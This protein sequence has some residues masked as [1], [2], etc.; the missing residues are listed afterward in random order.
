MSIDPT[1][2]SPAG[3]PITIKITGPNT[4]PTL[5]FEAASTDAPQDIYLALVFKATPTQSPLARQSLGVGGAISSLILVTITPTG[6]LPV[7]L[8]IKDFSPPTIHDSWLPLALTPS[9]SNNT[10]TMVRPEGLYEVISPVGKVVFTLPLYPHL[11]LGS[12][13]RLLKSSVSNL[14]SDLTWKP[15]WSNLGPYRLRLTINT[16]GGTKLSEI[17]KVV[18]ILPLRFLIFTTLLVLFSLI[19]LLKLK[20]HHPPQSSA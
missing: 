8:E 2:L 6:L 5:T 10:P 4:T 9:L 18:W 1:P 7:D 15:H 13:Y 16:Q 19:I 17:E 20:K 3:L 14:P 11:I 12:S